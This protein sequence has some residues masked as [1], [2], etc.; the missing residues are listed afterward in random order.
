[1]LP[2][3]FAE[4][5]KINVI[6]YINPKYIIDEIK[7]KPYLLYFT[8]GKLYFRMD[9]IDESL[10][11]FEKAVEFKPTF[12]TAYH[13]IGV[14]YYGKG[15]YDNALDVFMGAVEIDDSYAKAHYS[16]GVLYFELGDLDNAIT[17]FENVVQLEPDNAN[18][19]FDLAQNYVARFRK[20]EDEDKPDYRD[21]EQALLYLKRTEKLNPGVPYVLNNIDIIQSIADARDDLIQP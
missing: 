2:I 19:N 16:I 5:T 15:E 18:A 8:L 1:M 9:M 3:A 13:N 6:S 21:L 17:Y 14:I 20:S 11:M 10:E 7:S 12:I 4:S